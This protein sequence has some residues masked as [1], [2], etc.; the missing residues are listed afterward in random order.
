MTVVVG[1]EK[2][3]YGG[4]R[5]RRFLRDLD[6]G[7]RQRLAR[8][9]EG[10]VMEFV[11]LDAQSGELYV[12]VWSGANRLIES[13]LF[14]FGV[15]PSE[16]R[17]AV[18]GCPI[19]SVGIQPL[20]PF[21]KFCDSRKRLVPV[22]QICPHEVD[23]F[24]GV[25]AELEEDLWELGLGEKAGASYFCLLTYEDVFRSVGSSLEEVCRDNVEELDVIRWV[26]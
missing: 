14:G 18:V 16:V 7:S 10:E 5:V 11:L 3:T 25:V 8:E 21:W 9:M 22:G 15:V 4:C 19:G 26:Q 1:G 24:K 2:C 23:G 17:D 12:D 13:S 20:W 6:D